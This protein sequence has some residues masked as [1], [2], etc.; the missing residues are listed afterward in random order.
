MPLLSRIGQEKLRCGPNLCSAQTLR[1][2]PTDNISWPFGTRGG[3]T[4][5]SKEK[6]AAGG[7]PGPAQEE[8][9]DLWGV[10]A[11]S[12]ASVI[13]IAIGIWGVLAREL[14]DHSAEK[15]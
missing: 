14:K 6:G 11:T 4:G 7:C 13:A 2:L 1:I 9:S 3:R 12:R 5:N 8:R 10:G 15:E